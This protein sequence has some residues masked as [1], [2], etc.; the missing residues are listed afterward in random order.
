MTTSTPTTVEIRQLY[1]YWTPPFHSCTVANVVLIAA[2]SRH[3]LRTLSKS[4]LMR[5]GIHLENRLARLDWGDRGD[6][7]C[8][9]FPAASTVGNNDGYQLT[10]RFLCSGIKTPCG[11][12]G[13]YQRFQGA[14]C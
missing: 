12:P 1:V 2:G 11:L 10:F 5:N 8:P 3:R 14:Y 9:S 13:K 6:V 7:C 4:V